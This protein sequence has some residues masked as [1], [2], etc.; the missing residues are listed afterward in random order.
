MRP[1]IS[2]PPNDVPLPRIVPI[3]VPPCRRDPKK[4][5]EDEIEI[6]KAWD[7]ISN[8]PPYYIRGTRAKGKTHKIAE[9][10]KR[11]QSKTENP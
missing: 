2:L 4:C 1:T 11:I 10:I 6:R 8:K 9:A 3:D 7:I 5:E